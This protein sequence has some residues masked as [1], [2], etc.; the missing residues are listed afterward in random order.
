MPTL[1]IGDLHG[2]HQGLV[3]LLRA[4]GA[5]D[6]TLTRQ[7][8]WQLIQ[9]GDC[10]HGGAHTRPADQACLELALALCDA[11]LIGNHELPLIWPEARFPGWTGM[12]PP[13]PATLGAL[14]A[15][16]ARG[17]L[18]PAVAL[19][20][21]LLTHAGLHPLHRAGL[22]GA[23]VDPRDAAWLAA[24]LTRLF[25]ERVAT[26]QPHPLFD[27]VGPARGGQA[28]APGIFWCDWSE[29]TADWPAS[30]PVA[31]PPP[32]R[33]I[34]GHT[35]QPHRPKRRGDHWCVDVG[36]ARSG[37]V[38]GLVRAAPGAPWRPLVVAGGGDR[39]LTLRVNNGP[40]SPGVEV[41]RWR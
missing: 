28:D 14:L 32:L 10:V 20:G 15:A 8:G 31:P 16:A 3:A 40:Q 37:K 25:R 22:V 30:R 13:A 33:Q 18:V 2:D 19:D 4:A 38:A 9:L 24:V 17:K 1:V 36:A 39:A 34:V 6:A 21:W 26:G 35:P 7:P 27:A 12:A 41:D 11:I 23:G 29:L 5:V